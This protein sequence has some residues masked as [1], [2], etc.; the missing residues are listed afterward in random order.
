MDVLIDA[1]LGSPHIAVPDEMLADNADRVSPEA[2]V[3]E[4]LSSDGEDEDDEEATEREEDGETEEEEKDVGEEE[5]EAIGKEDGYQEDGSPGLSEKLLSRSSFTP[6][7]VIDVDSGS[8]TSILDDDADE[9][10]DR[11]TDS[12]S[13]ERDRTPEPVIGQWVEQGEPPEE[14]KPI[15][16]TSLGLAESIDVAILEVREDER[17]VHLQEQGKEEIGGMVEASLPVMEDMPPT[18]KPER[19]K[20]EVGID[21]GEQEVPKD[22]FEHDAANMDNSLAAAK[23]GIETFTD[24]PHANESSMEGMLASPRDAEQRREKVSAPDLTQ[25][26]ESSAAPPPGS[27]GP[28]RDEDTSEPY[29]EE[30]M[31]PSQ[32]IDADIRIAARPTDTSLAEALVTQTEPPDT[33][34]LLPQLDEPEVELVHVDERATVDA[35]SG[36]PTDMPDHHLPPRDSIMPLPFLLQDPETRA[37]PIPSLIVEPPA[38]APQPDS[39][40]VLLSREETPPNL[41]DPYQAPA[42]SDLP[43]QRLNAED[44]DPTGSPSPSMV[45]EPPSKR[46]APDSVDIY[47]FRAETPPVLPDPH[48]AP[49]DTTQTAPIFSPRLSGIIPTPSLIVEPPTDMP[50][51]ATSIVASRLESSTPMT[52]THI[53]PPG[54]ERIIPESPHGVESTSSPSGPILVHSAE[55]RNR[56]EVQRESVGVSLETETGTPHARPISDNLPTTANDLSTGPMALL[57]ID[58]PLFQTQASRLRHHHGALGQDVRPSLDKIESKIRSHTRRSTSPVPSPPVTRSHCTYRKLRISDEEL[59]ATILVPHCTLADAER[60]REGEWEDAGDPSTDEERDAKP[61]ALTYQRPLIHPRLA[62]KL[63]RIVGKNI[64]D[65]GHCFLSHASDGASAQDV[66]DTDT[67]GAHRNS[68]KRKSAEPA[69][70]DDEDNAIDVRSTPAIPTAR[71]TRRTRR[72][73]AIRTPETST[74]AV[75]RSQKRNVTRSVSRSTAMATDEEGSTAQTPTPAAH[76]TPPTAPILSLER[77]QTRTSTARAKATQNEES[78]TEREATPVPT[79]SSRK[80][81]SR[82]S[83]PGKKEDAAMVVKPDTDGEGSVMSAIEA[84]PLKTTSTISRGRRSAAAEQQDS[85]SNLDEDDEARKMTPTPGPVPA[86]SSE[87]KLRSSASPKKQAAPAAKGERAETPTKAAEPSSPPSHSTRKRKFRLSAT[88]AKEDAP[89]RAFENEEAEEHEGDETMATASTPIRET[90]SMKRQAVASS[91]APNVPVTRGT[92]GGA[93]KE[94]GVQV[95]TSTTQTP[96]RQKRGIL[97]KMLRW[98]RGQ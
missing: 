80:R 7:E 17:P 78:E 12:A 76:K 65:E 88:E 50:I 48:A 3:I 10:Q 69:D 93:E 81:K 87:R 44:F 18:I 67:R 58:E 90:R 55:D 59:V 39:V 94:D 20:F 8:D 35:I 6:G 83:A 33:A 41:P 57:D 13:Y 96:R 19:P 28:N 46:P 26:I 89:W 1:M 53:A 64:F 14:L 29:R 60:L 30:A 42:D 73:A 84:A 61:H 68:R 47:A 92:T 23:Q 71:A 36:V 98:G 22:R 9:E 63:H 49:P 77:R 91:A 34:T 43:D 37:R 56:T 21:T 38:E 85:V 15:E 70:S 74:L 51:A 4:V 54:A 79:A 31:L 40:P 62:A 25:P 11:R 24:E 72:R 52:K 97:G 75:T 66:D 95:E 45:V 86:S 32:E 82:K 16:S 2:D 5:E 27:P